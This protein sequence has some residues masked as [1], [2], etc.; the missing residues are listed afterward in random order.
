MPGTHQK[1]CLVFWPFRSRSKQCEDVTTVK[2]IALRVGFLRRRPGIKKHT[3]LLPS[4]RAVKKKKYTPSLYTTTTG[5]VVCTYR[6]HN[7][8]FWQELV[9]KPLIDC[10]YSF[11]YNFRS[12]VLAEIEIRGVDSFLNPRGRGGGRQ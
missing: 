10:F 11:L 1:L 8:A 9:W 6:V 5:A 12:D 7:P 4:S 3:S 2:V